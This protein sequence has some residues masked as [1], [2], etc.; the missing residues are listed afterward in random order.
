M[1]HRW[2]AVAG[3]AFFILLA[4]ISSSFAVRAEGSAEVVSERALPDASL[5]EPVAVSERTISVALEL[6]RDGAR[7][8]GFAI[9]N[10]PYD[11]AE[12]PAFLVQDAR[13]P[14]TA[15]I[16]IALIGDDGGRFTRRLEMRGLCL[17]HGPESDPHIEGDTIR[18]HRESVVVDLPRIVGYDHR[19]SRARIASGAWSASRS[20]PCRSV[21]RRSVSPRRRRPQRAEARFERAPRREPIVWGTDPA[22]GPATCRR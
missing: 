17:D 18:L 20:E 7:L 3:S 13:G 15:Q 8:L 1:T 10:R 2:T 16:E 21:P 14:E 9:K 19:G 11:R 6:D 4:L 22:T 5:A 12:D